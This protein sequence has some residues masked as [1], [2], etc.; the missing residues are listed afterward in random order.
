MKNDMEKSVTDDYDSPWKEMLAKYFEQFMEFFFPEI[1]PKI[2][3]SKGYE[4]LDK[5]LRQI[6]R[7][8]EIGGRLADKLFKV[9]TRD[10]EETWVLIHVEVQA[11]WKKDFPHGIFVYNYR[12]FEL[13]KHNVLS[14]AVFADEHP[15]W[16]PSVYSNKIL[17]CN[18]A[19]RFP[20]V[21]LLDFRKKADELE[22]SDNPFAV[23]V[24]AHLKTMETKK[25]YPVRWRWKL[26][27]TKALYRR[28]FSRDDVMNLFDFIDWIMFLPED[29]ENRFYREILEF[30]EERKMRFV[31]IAERTGMEKGMEKGVSSL[32]IKQLNRRFG[33]ITPSLETGLQS[34]RM[35]VLE[36]LGESMF[37]FNDL[38]DVEKWWE[39]HGKQEKS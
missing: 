3:W 36:R 34:S 6:I 30:E 4:S 1:H 24:A 38:R 35:E 29:L 26:T 27:M 11:Q 19:F 14:L 21:K 37:D 12:I 13:Y 32:I 23:V 18:T 17:G 15:N 10:G 31:N 9:W 5:E 33:C 22:K 20:A 25:D 39:K 28:G 7:E 2:D 16:R 8:A